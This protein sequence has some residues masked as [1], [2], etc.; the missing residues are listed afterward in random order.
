MESCVKMCDYV[1][2]LFEDIKRFLFD[3]STGKRLTLAQW[4]RGYIRNHKQYKKNSILEK[5]VM[6]DLM[7]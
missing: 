4:M 7:I 2:L 5:I 6:D 1:R 3:V